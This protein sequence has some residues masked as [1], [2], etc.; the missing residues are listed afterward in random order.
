MTSCSYIDPNRIAPGYVLAYN[1]IKS[2]IL[3]SENTN[4]T[5]EIIKSIPYASLLV[6]IGNGPYGLM[7][8]QSIQENTTTWVSADGVYFVISNGRII[9]TKGLDNNLIKTITPYLFHSEE[10][11]RSSVIED[12]KFY[13]SY[14][15]PFLANLE[16]QAS[17]KIGEESSH[18]LLTNNIDLLL[19]TEK[20][21]NDDINWRKENKYWVDE[22]GF[23]W[24]SE[25]H[26]SPKIPKIYIEVTK[27]PS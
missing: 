5:P 15:K 14:D 21:K 16:V 24:K 22:D 1:S 2:A 6:R 23:I 9:K 26:I 27:K 25:Q 13:Y 20:L 18:S 7:I 11:L 17:Y 8:L 3:G 19:I 4:I 10:F 12:L